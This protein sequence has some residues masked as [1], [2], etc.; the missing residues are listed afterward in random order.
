MKI[1]LNP[2]LELSLPTIQ[3][4]PEFLEQVKR[5]RDFHASWVALPADEK[6]YREYLYKAEQDNQCAL[7]LRLKSTH[8]MI[9]VFNISKIVRGCFQSA[10]LGFYVFDGYQ[11]QGLMT[12]GLHQLLEFA[13]TIL[14]LHRLEANIQPSNLASIALV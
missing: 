4:C 1:L 7:F 13:F 14:N 11:R 10:Y 9:G 12:Q 6:Q 3:D 8:Q 5:S 2:A